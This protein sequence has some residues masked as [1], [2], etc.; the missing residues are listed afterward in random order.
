[1]LEILCIFGLTKMFRGDVQVCINPAKSL[2]F[3]PAGACFG[4]QAVLGFLAMSEMSADCYALYSQTSIIILTLAWTIVFRTRLSGTCWMG[5]VTVALGM[6]GFNLSDT[7]TT[8][9]GLV[10]MFFK[11]CFQSFACLYAEMFMKSDPAPLYIQMAWSKPIELVS[12]VVMMFAIPLVEQ[13]VGLPPRGPTPWQEITTDGFFHDWNYLV[14]IIMVFNM[15][16]TFMNAT[17]AKKFDSVVK[18]VA[19]VFDILYPTQVLIQFIN[20]PAYTDLKIFSAC[21][22]VCG[23]LSFVLAKNQMKRSAEQTRELEELQA[24]AGKV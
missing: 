8:P 22:I 15:G 21:T 14:V 13:I 3:A 24:T 9:R 2:R 6:A 7:S 10:F 1:M 18:G 16:D 11:I 5:I 20:P 19:G 17:I 4:I 12:T 23:S